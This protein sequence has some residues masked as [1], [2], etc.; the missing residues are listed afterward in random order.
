MYTSKAG[1]TRKRAAG[2]EDGPCTGAAAHGR[3]TPLARIDKRGASPVAAGGRR[4][5]FQAKGST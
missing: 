5:V 3:P 2:R 4:Y 1:N